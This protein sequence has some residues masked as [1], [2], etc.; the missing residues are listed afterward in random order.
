M[1]LRCGGSRKNCQCNQW[2]CSTS[3]R[4]LS[5]LPFTYLPTC[6]RILKNVPCTC[7]PVLFKQCFHKNHDHMI[8]ATQNLFW[9]KPSRTWAVVTHFRTIVFFLSLWAP[10]EEETAPPATEAGGKDYWSDL[11]YKT[12]L[13]FI[14]CCSSLVSPWLICNVLLRHVHFPCSIKLWLLDET[15]PENTRVLWFPK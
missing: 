9:K 2:A 7:F 14:V 6:G 11:I 8:Y 12:F 4:W 5:G 13:I 15:T 1:H 10:P 3:N